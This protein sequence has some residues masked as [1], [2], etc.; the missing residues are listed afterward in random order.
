MQGCIYSPT[1]LY[2]LPYIGR[3]YFL[4]VW[5]YAANSSLNSINIVFFYYFYI[6]IV[7][8]WHQ[9][10]SCDSFALPVALPP[11]SNRYIDAV[12]DTFSGSSICAIPDEL[13]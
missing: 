9:I 12:G 3:A 7:P 2:R 6:G 4:E 11:Q 1:F 10:G 5:P 8:I 13:G